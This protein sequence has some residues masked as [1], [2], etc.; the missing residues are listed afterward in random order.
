MNS[1]ALA[2]LLLVCAAPAEAP[3]SSE[4]ERRTAGSVEDQIR[5]ALPLGITEAQAVAWLRERLPGFTFTVEKERPGSILL[6][7]FG[8]FIDAADPRDTGRFFRLRFDAQR[9]LTWVHVERL[10]PIPI[11][12]VEPATK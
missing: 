2:A 3:T 1:A 4:M 10:P 6:L 12:S 11:Y 9:R 8:G 5:A 7:W